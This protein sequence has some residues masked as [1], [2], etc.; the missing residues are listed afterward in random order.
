MS[1]H[2]YVIDNASGAAVRADLNNALSAIVTSNS[3]ATAPST[4]YA[5]QVWADTTANKLKIRNGANNAWFEVGSLDTANLGLMLASYFPNVNANIT[6]SDEELNKLDGATVTTAELSLLSGLTATSTELNLLDGLTAIRDEDTMVSN[7]ATAL[8]TQQSIKAYV[9]SQVPTNLGKVLQVV[10]T[11]KTDTFSTTSNVFADITGLSVSITPTASTSKVMVFA[12]ISDGTS[13]ACIRAFRLMRGATP[14]GVGN[15]AGSRNQS[16]LGSYQGSADT[17]HHQ[18]TSPIS[19]LDSPATTSPVTY[20]V[21]AHAQD[22]CTVYI[23]RSV[24][25]PDSASNGN[26]SSSSITVMEIGA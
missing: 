25:D 20:K 7:S 2:D 22:A 12:T 15:A 24:N 5:Y 1:Q 19:H 13:G 18:N 10:S 9:D 3:A 16:N 4:T 11:T 6:A 26:R 14:I 23:N 8:A 17:G 21:Q